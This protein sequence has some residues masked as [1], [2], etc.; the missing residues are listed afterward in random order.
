[1][2]ALRH[3]DFLILWLGA[4][5]SFTGSMI[6]NTAQQVLVF[7]ITGDAAKLGFVAFCAS[8]PVAILGP[9]AGVLVDMHDKRRLLIMTQVV[10]AVSALSIAACISF[11]VIQYAFIVAAALVIGVNGCIEIPARQSVISRVVPPEDLPSAIPLQAMTFNLARV[12]GPAVGALLIVAVGTE[13]CYLINGISYIGLIIAAMAIKTDLSST[14]ERQPIK[15]LLME[16][17]RFTFRDYRL[18]TLFIMEGIVSACGLFYIS[19]MA[20]IADRVLKVDA[21]GLGLALSLIGIGAIV[22]LL[23]VANKG[24]S[25]T[26]GWI[27]RIAMVVF[28]TSLIGL[29]FATDRIVAFALLA[30]LGMSSIMQFNT[31]NTLFQMIAPP[32]LR[33]RVIAMHVWALS[34]FGPFG[35][36]F[37]SWLAETV[38]IPVALRSAGACILVG[39]VWGWSQRGAFRNLP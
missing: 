3:R 1:M 13:L 31:T 24:S 23:F 26:R 28:G 8:A 17:I 14:N 37:F 25:S 33:G 35:V 20:A 15:E 39:A 32:N 19:I 38:S 18:R 30:M 4:L 29:G 9:I 27:V 12:V 7:Q 5:F 22:G 16:G 6:Q 21:K 36:L 2:R 11:K 10:F 34:G